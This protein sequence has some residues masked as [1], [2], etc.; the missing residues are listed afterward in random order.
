M[1]EMERL[2]TNFPSWIENLPRPLRRLANFLR[3]LPFISIILGDRPLEP[4]VRDLYSDNFTIDD[5]VVE[6]G[7]RMGDATRALA[8][9]SRHVYSFEPSKSNFLVLRTLTWTHRN[10]DTYNLALS[11]ITGD[12][13]LYRD[14]TFSGVSSLKRL[15]DVDYVARERVS[16]G[17]LDGI[18]F[19]LRPTSLVV[20]CEGSE[21]AVLRGGRRLLPFLRTV[22]V[23]THILDD[24]SSTLEPVRDELTRF[25]PFVRIDRVGNEFWVIARK[26]Q[27]HSSRTVAP[28]FDRK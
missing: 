12:A 24:G 10:V 3:R 7:A 22:L 19:K 27:T 23:E 8:T 28:S 18:D 17:T 1:S 5:V 6:V 25:F 16:V 26:S 9:I 15:N 21:Q 2:A 11:D 14:R 20:D 4:A 13:Y